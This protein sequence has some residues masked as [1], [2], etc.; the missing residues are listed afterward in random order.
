MVMLKEWAS[1]MLFS[2]TAG[3]GLNVSDAAVQ[4]LNM[5]MGRSVSMLPASGNIS[6]SRRHPKSGRPHCARLSRSSQFAVRSSQHAARIHELR[7]GDDACHSSGSWQDKALHPPSHGEQGLPRSGALHPRSI[8][9][10]DLRRCGLSGTAACGPMHSACRAGR[11]HISARGPNIVRPVR[12]VQLLHCGGTGRTDAVGLGQDR[13]PIRTGHTPEPLQREKEKTYLTTILIRGISCAAHAPVLPSTRA[14][15]SRELMLCTTAL[16]YGRK[17]TGLPGG[18]VEEAHLIFVRVPGNWRPV[19]W[20]DLSVHD[21]PPV[22]SGRSLASSLHP[23]PAAGP[24]SDPAPSRA[25]QSQSMLTLS[26]RKTSLGGRLVRLSGPV[27]CAV[28]L[29]SRRGRAIAN[30]SR[31]IGDAI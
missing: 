7:D 15:C 22:P 10:V 21:F 12:P 31:L 24:R 4:R 13:S 9:Y 23:Q 8:L 16:L 30:K 20:S 1:S 25:S 26:P 6:C 27:P 3:S 18:W 19:K 28:T 2:V 11:P 29:P 5:R 17:R 14:A